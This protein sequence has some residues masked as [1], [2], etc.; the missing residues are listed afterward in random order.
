MEDKEICLEINGIESG[1][2]KFKNYFEQIAVPFKINA[3]FGSMSVEDK[4]R[5]Q[6]SKKCWIY[7][8]LFTDVDKKVRGHDHITRTF[9]GSTYSNCNI[10]LKSARNVPVIFH[11]LKGYMSTWLFMKLV[12]LM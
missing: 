2:I 12:S 7:N 10:N 9:R 3:D 6:S 8:K 11:N 5:F 4:G 1:T